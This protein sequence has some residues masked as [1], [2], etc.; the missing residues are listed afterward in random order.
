MNTI[1]S[2]MAIGAFLSGCVTTSVEDSIAGPV[3]V[4]FDQYELVTGAGPGQTVVAG[5]FLGGAVADVAAGTT[6]G[7]APAAT[8]ARRRHSAAPSRARSRRPTPA[9]PERSRARRDLPLVAAKACGRTAAGGR[10]APRRRIH[11]DRAKRN[12]EKRREGASQWQP[13]TSTG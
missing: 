8:R 1:K 13:R 6:A 5:F 3:E 2:V 11:S 4:S 10:D 7:G 9:A 12:A